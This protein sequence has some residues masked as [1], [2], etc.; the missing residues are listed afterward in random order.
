[1][2]ITKIEIK[3][4][5]AFYGTHQIA[6]TKEGKNLLVYGENGSGKS[7]LYM[8]LKLFFASQY[9]IPTRESIR[10]NKGY[11]GIGGAYRRKKHILVWGQFTTS[12]AIR[13]FFALRTVTSNYISEKL[14]IQ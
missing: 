5:R 12:V 7:S 13:T 3:N 8:A 6:L 11:F 10:W 4:F 2:K 9:Y 1:M 14:H